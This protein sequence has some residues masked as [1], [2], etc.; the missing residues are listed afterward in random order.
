M[1]YCLIV[2][3]GKAM[4]MENDRYEALI[5]QEA[6]VWSEAALSLADRVKPDWQQVKRLP[7]QAVIHARHVELILS[8]IRPGWRVLEIGCASGWFSLEMARRGAHVLGIDVASGAIDLARQYA[9]TVPVAGSV[10]YEVA[11]V[12]RMSLETEH[13]DLIVASGVLHHLV[14][15][16]NV[17]EQCR[18]ALMP[19]GLL[20]VFDA[21]DTP[22]INALISGA[23]MLI[24]PT[25]LGYREKFR[26]LFRLR[27]NALEHVTASIEA[28]GLS[29]FEGY[30]RHQEPIN[31]L[32]KKFGA[33][34]F[35]ESS[36]FVDY[37][38]AQLNLPDPMI[39]TLGR[40]IGFFDGILVKLHLLKGLN[41]V[42]IG[43]PRK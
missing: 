3:V 42:F 40:F 15:V 11:D 4:K 25:H 30:G 7:H 20:Y 13:Y 27:R 12:N 22:K 41:Y 2:K 33:S 16:E 36:A 19:E 38:I 8:K 9:Q 29:P 5:Q 26:H 14:E 28:R 10:R 24:L 17:L 21:F 23:L 39:I 31:I 32:E 34:F 6:K 18:K 37:V 35:V 43:T 1:G